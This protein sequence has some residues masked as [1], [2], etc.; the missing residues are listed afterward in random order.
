M[1]T[2]IG[3]E[4]GDSWLAIKVVVD[5]GYDDRGLGERGVSGLKLNTHGGRKWC[6]L[7]KEAEAG[8]ARKHPGG[9]SDGATKRP[10]QKKRPF[11]GRR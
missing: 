1:A 3:R 9:N 5:A 7:R 11:R 10:P 2:K 6:W 8:Q 4:E